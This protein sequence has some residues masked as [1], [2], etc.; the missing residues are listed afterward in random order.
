MRAEVDAIG[1]G[2]G[3]ILVDDPLLTARGVYRERPLARVS[4]STAGCAR[5]PAPAALDTATP[6]LSSS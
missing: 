1:V 6:G 4:F 5:R 2:L 3:T